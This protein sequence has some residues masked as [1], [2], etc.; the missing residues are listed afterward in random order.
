MKEEIKNYEEYLHLFLDGLNLIKEGLITIDYISKQHKDHLFRLQVS[1]LH[2]HAEYLINEI[3]ENKFMKQFSGKMKDVWKTKG[4]GFLGK[5]KI[6]YAANNFDIN[7]FKTLITLNEIRNHLSHNLNADIDSQK[8]KI[9]SM[10]I[11]PSFEKSFGK[12]LDLTQHL[13]FSCITSINL[14]AEYLFR[15]I[16]QEQLKHWIRIDFKY[17]PYY[18]FTVELRPEYRNSQIIAGNKPPI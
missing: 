13:I 8:K 17:C 12:K 5:L 6:V 4:E 11:D 3:I 2:L 15:N 1:L 10:S 14:L 18:F 16:K 9:F 7:F